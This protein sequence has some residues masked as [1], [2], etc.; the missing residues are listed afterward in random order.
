[1]TGVQTCALPI[2]RRSDAC[3]DR[4]GRSASRG[5]T[6]PAETSAHPK[7]FQLYVSSHQDLCQKYVKNQEGKRTGVCH[8]S[9]PPEWTPTVVTAPPPGS[10]PQGCRAPGSPALQLAARHAGWNDGLG[11]A[12]DVSLPLDAVV[13]PPKNPTGT[14]PA[15]ASPLLVGL[16]SRKQRKGRRGLKHQKKART[17]HLP[18]T[19]QQRIIKNSL[20]PHK[21]QVE[22]GGLHR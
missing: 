8:G 12:P 19:R 5:S 14:H 13:L 22:T 21:A 1:M 2:Y 16:R 20:L 6:A 7:G 9:L 3:N 15:P 4:A 10:G 11:D 17:P 18:K